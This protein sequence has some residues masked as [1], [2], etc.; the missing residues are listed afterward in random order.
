NNASYEKQ[1]QFIGNAAHELQTPLAIATNKLELLIEKGELN[2]QQTNSVAEVLSL[3]ERLVRLNRSLLLLSKIENNQFLEN[4]E[5][6][7]NHLTRRCIE[8]MDDMINFKE[9]NLSLEE[10][11]TFTQIMDPSLGYI[12]VGNLLRN[13]LFHNKEHGK[14]TIH[15]ASNTFRIANSGLK[16]PLNQEKL[17]TRFHKNES[18]TNGSG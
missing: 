3:I 2:E 14:V 4:E 17:F 11:G 7:F 9:L 8:E 12:V 1:T 18:S 15:I 6:T 13:A 10:T 16:A 5:L